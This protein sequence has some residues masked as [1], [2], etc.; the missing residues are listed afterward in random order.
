MEGFS[1]K[2]R[3]R[4][5]GALGAAALALA[6]AAAWAHVC[7]IDIEKKVA[8]DDN[9][10]GVPN[11]SFLDTVTQDID[12]CVV[13]EICVSNTG[14][15][16]LNDVVVIDP[17]LGV[18]I[19]FG[20]IPFSLTPPVTECRYITEDAPASECTA[21]PDACV[22]REVEGVN[23]ARIHAAIC[24]ESEDSA[25]N[26]TTHPA[27]DCEDSAEVKC[28]EKEGCL[29]RTPGFWGNHPDITAEFLPVT[30][31]GI[32]LSQVLA[33]VQGSVTED[34]CSL[35]VNTPLAPQHAQLIRQCAAAALNIAASAELGGSCSTA[36][37]P[38]RF[39][40]CCGSAAIC[41][42]VPANCIEDLDRFNNSADT[43]LTALPQGNAEPLQ[44]QLARDSTFVNV[45]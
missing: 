16:D 40:Q 38:T 33:G 26:L 3:L 5:A 12:Q 27:S 39:A 22:C 14:A 1:G 29:T 41:A 36:L 2:R 42:S 15:Q 18:T 8:L 34:L 20:D 43:L 19:S 21:D 24:E 7:S 6:P 9:C 11:G 17:D 10:D 4:F 31:C 45:R 28:E 35:G 13:Y 23:T 25:C 30:S 37:T 32:P 44:C